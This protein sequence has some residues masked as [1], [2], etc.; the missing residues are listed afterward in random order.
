MTAN[1][2]VALARAV[3]SLADAAGMPDT[4]WASDRR[5]ALAREVLDVPPNGRYS[6]EHLWDAV[7]LERSDA[8]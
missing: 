3:L 7:A 4:Y 8:S 2:E 1:Q 6:H 5:V